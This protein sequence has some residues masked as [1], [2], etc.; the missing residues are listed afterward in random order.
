MC[1][2]L[3]E[4]ASLEHLRLV[5]QA[6]HLSDPWEVNGEV[7]RPLPRELSRTDVALL[8]DIRHDTLDWVGDLVRL[9]KL[10]ELEV[11]PDFCELPRP[12]TSNMFV[13]MAF[14][15]SINKGFK[16]FLRWRLGLD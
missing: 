7:N 4:N 1:E 5:V 14:S 13:F 16:E 15:A 10:R 9:N 3:S 6:G 11:V 8:V 2:Y 12:E